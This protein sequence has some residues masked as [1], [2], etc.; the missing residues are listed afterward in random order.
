MNTLEVA[1]ELGGIEC[2]DAPE[3][4]KAKPANCFLEQKHSPFCLIAKETKCRHQEGFTEEFKVTVP[5]CCSG[6]LKTRTE[7]EPKWIMMIILGVSS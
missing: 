1:Q 4:L 6:S 2:L 7:T 5:S 3:V